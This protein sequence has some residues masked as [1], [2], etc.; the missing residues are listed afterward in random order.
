MMVCKSNKYKTKGNEVNRFKYHLV[1]RSRHY[2]AECQDF[3]V[4]K[5]T[6]IP[7]RLLL[8]PTNLNVSFE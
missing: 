1:N 3:D 8:R 4:L 5:I 6:W 2:S 7:S